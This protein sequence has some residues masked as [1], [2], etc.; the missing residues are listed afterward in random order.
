LER[1]VEAVKLSLKTLC[2]PLTHPMLIKDDS[3][4]SL[5]HP[6]PAGWTASLKLSFGRILI[7][8]TSNSVQPA[9]RPASREATRR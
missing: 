3:W 4:I 7:R 9:F 1:D 6:M 8:H 2:F 5:A